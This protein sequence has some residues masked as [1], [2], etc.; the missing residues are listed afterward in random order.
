MGVQTGWHVVWTTDRETEIFYLFRSAESSENALTSGIPIYSIFTHKWFCPN[1][2]W[3]QNTNTLREDDAE[4]KIGQSWLNERL[5]PELDGE[6]KKTR[7]VLPWK[8][9]P[10]ILGMGYPQMEL[11]QSQWRNLWE[12]L[13]SWRSLIW[14]WS[15]TQLMLCVC[16]CESFLNKVCCSLIWF[17]TTKFSK[18]KKYSMLDQSKVKPYLIRA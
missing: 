6:D 16:V 4:R 2:E 1:T 3:G 10:W 12:Q 9:D 13:W 15:G 5:C 18:W 14:L 17:K 8:G 11:D 7:V